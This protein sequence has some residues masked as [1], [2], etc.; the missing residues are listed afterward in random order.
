MATLAAASSSATPAPTTGNPKEKEIKGPFLHAWNDPLAN[1]KTNSACVKLVDLN[2]DGDSKLCICDYDK[3]M[4]VY[5]G[6]NLV[7]EYAIL[8]T[9]TAMCV[10]YM[11]ATLVCLLSFLFPYFLLITSFLASYSLHRCRSRITRLY[12]SPITTVQKGILFSYDDC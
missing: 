3:K 1:V 7:M 2:C 4:R 11:E 10:A 5:K 12:L 6:T 8:D 9:P